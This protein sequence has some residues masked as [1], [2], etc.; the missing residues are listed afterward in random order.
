MADSATTIVRTELIEFIST[1][2]TDQFNR[3]GRRTTG[4]A[5]AEAIRARF[6]S[7]SFEQVGLTRLA[8]AVRLAEEAGLLVRHRDVKHLEVSPRESTPRT[9]SSS[10]KS[11]TPHVR[12]DVW[13]ALVFVNDTNAHF[14]DRTTGKLITLVSGQDAELQDHQENQRFVRL[15]SIPPE[16]QKQWMRDFVESQPALNGADAPFDEEK[17]WIVFP[18][19]LQDRDPAADQ[20]WRRFR[21]GRVF[22]FVKEWGR[23][24]GVQEE[25]WLSARQPLLPARSQPAYCPHEQE[26]TR[27]A[28]LAAIEDLPFEQLADLAIPV[29]YLLR[30]LKVR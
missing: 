30:H 19:W 12:P 15:S 18:A 20:N 25:M 28:I 11:A 22:S 16:T 10:A 17:W 24:N 7:F 4:A 23:K 21:A 8:D 5:L 9:P 26:V 2:V 13:R 14:L 29:R 6:P 1:Y 27:R 3:T